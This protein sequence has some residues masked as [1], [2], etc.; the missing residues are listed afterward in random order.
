MSWC[1]MMSFHINSIDILNFHDFDYCCIITG[2]SNDEAIDIDK[3]VT[4]KRGFF[5]NKWFKYFIGNKD[6]EKT[7]QL[8]ILVSRVSGYTRNIDKT[9]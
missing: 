9:K 2:N 6:L 8:C 5:G 1:I 4:C 7:N 3:I